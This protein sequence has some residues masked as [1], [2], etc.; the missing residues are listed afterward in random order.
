MFNTVIDVDFIL[1][2]W[3]L[4]RLQSQQSSDAAE[5]L[6]LTRRFKTLEFVLQPVL[7]LNTYSM[8]WITQIL[9][10]LRPIWFTIVNFLYHSRQHCTARGCLD[11]RKARIY[12]CARD[13]STSVTWRP[14][15]HVGKADRYAYIYHLKR[16]SNG[17]YACD[18]RRRMGVFLFFF[19]WSV[20]YD[21]WPIL[22]FLRLWVVLHSGCRKCVIQ[23]P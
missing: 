14:R 12:E 20:Y 11:F 10:L 3:Y 21:V 8:Y 23:I 22:I 18:G 9:S 4:L 2:V 6:D 16:T 17:C 5:V 19:L 15:R 13:Y 7:R 1:F